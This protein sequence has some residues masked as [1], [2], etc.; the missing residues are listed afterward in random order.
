MNLNLVTMEKSKYSILKAECLSEYDK[1]VA[2]RLY[3]G[4]GELCDNIE[5]FKA[6]LKEEMLAKHIDVYR[7]NL[8]YEER[9]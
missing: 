1:K 7:I 2:V 5:D 9:S 8:T 3:E 4:D 6:K